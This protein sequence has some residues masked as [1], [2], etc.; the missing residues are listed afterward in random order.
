LGLTPRNGEEIYKEP[1][2]SDGEDEDVDEEAVLGKNF[3]GIS[4]EYNGQVMS[5]QTPA[6]IASFM[7]ERKRQYPTKQRIAEKAREQA[8]KRERELEFLRKIKAQTAKSKGVR[9]PEDQNG[10]RKAS[11]QQSGQY[12]LSEKQK[13]LAA[14]RKRVEAS[15]VNKKV[16]P[17]TLAPTTRSAPERKPPT[18][19]LGVNY[20]SDTSESEVSSVLSSSEVSSSEPDSDSDDEEDSDEPPEEQTSKIEP[21]K[22]KPPPPPPQPVVTPN[23]RVCDH[24][25]RDGHCK[26]GKKCRYAHPPRE[27]KKRLGLYDVFVQKEKQQADALALKAIKYLGNHGFLG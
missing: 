26:F 6:E 21:P 4:F 25:K 27:P 12:A 13:Q 1:D 19:N 22:P 8:T 10:D 9:V 2:L 18:I 3:N 7:K 23:T 11:K 5:L 17:S 20:E 14:L 16:S 15:A 24:W